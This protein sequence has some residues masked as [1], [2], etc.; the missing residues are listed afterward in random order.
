[1]KRPNGNELDRAVCEHIKALTEDKSLFLK[2]LDKAKKSI[3]NQQDDFDQKLY[4]LKKSE[5][6]NEKKIQSLVEA[7]SSGGETAASGYIT[8]QINEIHKQNEAIKK[9]I[10]DMEN[11]TM[12]QTLTGVEFDIL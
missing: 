2:E 3:M 12:G 6:E 10:S 4:N 1:M 8:T 5:K 9:Q 11:L 7:L